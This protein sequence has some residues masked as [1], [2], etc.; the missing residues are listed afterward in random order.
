MQG[1]K[2]QPTVPPTL[3]RRGN[4]AAGAHEMAVRAYTETVKQMFHRVAAR[5]HIPAAPGELADAPA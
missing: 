2:L 3:W 1:A 5:G 4:G